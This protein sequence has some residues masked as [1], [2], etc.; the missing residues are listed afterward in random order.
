M[1]D[2][3][4]SYVGDSGQILIEYASDYCLHSHTVEVEG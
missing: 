4:F 3:S 2:I 1:P